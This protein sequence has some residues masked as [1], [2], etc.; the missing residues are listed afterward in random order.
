MNLASI[1]AIY[2]FEMA[3]TRRTLMGFRLFRWRQS[4]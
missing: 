2:G 1:R 3:R 4:I